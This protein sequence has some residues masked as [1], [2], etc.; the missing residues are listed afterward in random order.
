MRSSS[1][2][3]KQYFGLNFAFAGGTLP[4]FASG[5]FYVLTPY[6]CKCVILYRYISVLLYFRKYV[7][8]YPFTSISSRAHARTY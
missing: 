7:Y 4:A 6:I 2:R 5:F 3:I 8:L 1:I